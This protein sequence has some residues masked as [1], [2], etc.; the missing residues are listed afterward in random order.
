MHDI[1]QTCHRTQSSVL[2]CVSVGICTV[3]VSQHQ[4]AL[5]EFEVHG[6]AD[7]DTMTN[8]A[9]LK[10][11][12]VLATRSAT[13][14]LQRNQQR[15]CSFIS[16]FNTQVMDHQN[17]LNCVVTITHFYYEFIIKTKH[18]RCSFMIPVTFLSSN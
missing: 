18:L 13:S 14:Q 5:L 6:V 16:G 2:F 15:I 17:F 12:S 10:V 1:F 11:N 9:Q 3:V 7:I 8:S 4:V